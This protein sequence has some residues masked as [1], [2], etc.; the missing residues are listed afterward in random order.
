MADERKDSIDPKHELP[1]PEESDP[2]NVGAQ[3]AD[4]NFMDD[5]RVGK[6]FIETNS[7]PEEEGE[8][9]AG[10]ADSLAGESRGRCI[11]SCLR[12]WCWW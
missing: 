10:G 8:A 7:S 4:P 1:W 3:F 2:A 9:A 5:R 12:L 6:N 11:G